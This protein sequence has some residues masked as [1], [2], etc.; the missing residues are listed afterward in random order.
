[1]DLILK[2]DLMIKNILFIIS[3]VLYSSLGFAQT[4]CKYTVQETFSIF[5]NDNKTDTVLYEIII[6]DDNSK[7]KV[8]FSLS[9]QELDNYMIYTV[10]TNAVTYEC[11]NYDMR[12]KLR[13]HLPA[14]YDS[15]KKPKKR[16]DICTADRL[17][18]Y[19]PYRVECK[20]D[21]CGYIVETNYYSLD[22][23]PKF[24]GKD[25]MVYR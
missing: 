19:P 18:G 22:K 6:F 17:E 24:L 5:D 13:F 3:L 10:D 9:N 23:I 16:L 25:I 11:S 20:K 12:G 4:N 14:V 1:M 15:L 2:N 7:P 21:S 8:L